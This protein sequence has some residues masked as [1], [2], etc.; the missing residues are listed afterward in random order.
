MG[1]DTQ[2]RELE[3]VWSFLH[4]RTLIFFFFSQRWHQNSQ[5]PTQRTSGLEKRAG[6][7]KVSSV[8]SEKPSLFP[9]E[10]AV[11]R[12]RPFPKV[13]S[14][15]I[16]TQFPAPQVDQGWRRCKPWVRVFFLSR[17]VHRQDLKPSLISL[18][19]LISTKF[20]FYSFLVAQILRDVSTLLQSISPR[21]VKIEI[22]RE[23]KQQEREK[24]AAEIICSSSFSPRI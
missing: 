7:T 8:C 16:K 19:F 9:L 14:T 1:W 10:C 20:S 2:S 17:Y 5:S 13:A 22:K 4:V 23:A 21:M 6:R 15:L 24:L 3:S 18:G 11:A 12:W